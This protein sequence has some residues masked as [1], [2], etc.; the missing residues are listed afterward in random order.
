MDWSSIYDEHGGE[1][2][3]WDHM[4]LRGRITVVVDSYISTRSYSPLICYLFTVNYVLGVGCLGIPYAFMRSGIVAG[5]LVVI[6]ISA[7]ALLTVLWIAEAGYIFRFIVSSHK[8]VRLFDN[9][10]TES[11]DNKNASENTALVRNPSMGKT[12][13]RTNRSRNMSEDSAASGGWQDHTDDFEVTDLVSAFLGA[14]GSAVYQ[15]SLITLTFIGLI[16]YCQVFVISFSSQVYP[17]C[18]TYIPIA[19]FGI[20][21]IPLSCFDLADQVFVQVAMSLLRF[22]TLGALFAGLLFAIFFDEKD[23]SPTKV[24]N[25][26][27]YITDD[28]PLFDIGGIGLMVSTAIFSQL[29]QH[30]VPGL[31]RPLPTGDQKNV[32]KIFSYALLTTGVLYICI[33]VTSVLYFGQNVS[34]SINLNFVGF[35]WGLSDS[36]LNGGEH[37]SMQVGEYYVA[38]ALSMLIVV[39]PA[40]DTLSVFPLIANTLGNNMLAA[41]PR[42]KK[43]VRNFVKAV[44]LDVVFPPV[45]KNFTY[46]GP[47]PVESKSHRATGIVGRLAAAIPAV[48]CCFWV[49]KLSV[50]LQL[51]GVCGI[52]VALVTPALMQREAVKFYKKFSVPTAATNNI[53]LKPFYIDSS[54]SSS[55][56]TTIVLVTAVC[57]L[58]VCIMQLYDTWMTM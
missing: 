46:Y 21:V 26:P 56:Y 42:W 29:F 28:A 58:F 1:T 10:L 12:K 47:L 15:V 5:S 27:P 53:A 14:N 50:T 3:S 32:P 48:L 2:G 13:A 17:D 23:S 39:F 54:Y 18:P 33:G 6:A 30:S 9:L 25:N 49:T 37:N 34:Q 31:I 36:V 51:A 57:G 44:K 43:L 8:D 45:D 52:I 7:I 38:M 40:L 55:F 41:F 24:D 35:R 19:I 11:P 22:V 16:A 20:I 4:D